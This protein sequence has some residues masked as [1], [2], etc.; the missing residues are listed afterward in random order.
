VPLADRRCLHCGFPLTRPSIQRS[1]YRCFQCERRYIVN[2]D[3]TL[4]E[5]TT[6]GLMNFIQENNIEPKRFNR[7]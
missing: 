2:M 5:R 1:G 6:R 3:G 4:S 7:S